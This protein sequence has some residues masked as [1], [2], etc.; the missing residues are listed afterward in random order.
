MPKRY[1]ITKDPKRRKH[2][3]EN[4]FV[5]LKNFKIEKKFSNQESAQKWENTKTNQ[6][7]GGPKIEGPIYGYSHD[8]TRKKPK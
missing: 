1:G 6:H 7:A 5:G 8:Y 4:Q 3:L 2:E